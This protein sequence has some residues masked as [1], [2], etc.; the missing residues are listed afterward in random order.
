MCLCLTPVA[1]YDT[2]ADTMYATLA[3]GLYGSEFDVESGIVSCGHAPSPKGL[4][5]IDLTNLTTSINYPVWAAKH[6]PKTDPRSHTIRSQAMGR[7]PYDFTSWLLPN[8]M[9]Q[10]TFLC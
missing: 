4:D 9:F 7:N 8:L 5:T 1:D 10:K 6:G 2:D 3:P